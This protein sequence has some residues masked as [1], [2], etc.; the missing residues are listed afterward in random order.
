[1]KFF[2]LI[3][4]GDLHIASKKKVVR[5]KEYS[6]LISAEEVLQKAHEDAE[7]FK[8]ET[9]EEC[10]QLKEEAR[11]EGFEEGLATFNEQLLHFDKKL[12]QIQH[13]TYLQILPLA[14]KAA[15]KI[16]A[17]ELELH[18]DTI[19]D[20]VRQ[21]LASV[22]QAQRITIY[23]NKADRDLLEEKKKE[24]KEVLEQVKVLIIQDRDDIELGG[25]V[26]ETEIGIVN[27]TL[28]NQFRALQAAFERHKK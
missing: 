22:T 1:M 23:V 14:L 24:I 17:K 8:K 4:Q 7:C 18:P 21:A 19:V 3:Y 16:V 27:T 5:R 25:C 11:K 26:I 12:K 13:E 10:A 9:E 6:A 20:I 2:S 15:K 28:E